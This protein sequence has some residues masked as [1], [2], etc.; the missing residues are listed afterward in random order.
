MREAIFK[1]FYCPR[2]RNWLYCRLI[3]TIKAFFQIPPKM[4]T[5]NA[6]FNIHKNP[7]LYMQWERPNNAP[8]LR[9]FYVVDK[10]RKQMCF[11]AFVTEFELLLWEQM[12]DT[13]TNSNRFRRTRQKRSVT[14]VFRC[15]GRARVAVEKLQIKKKQC[16]G[17]VCVCV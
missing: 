10:H 5:E 14:T 4:W 1:R 15:E 16:P 12:L 17:L 2:L 8:S 3:W 11:S 6:I 13:W 7:L 9:K